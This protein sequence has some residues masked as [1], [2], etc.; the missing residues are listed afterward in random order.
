[1][2]SEPDPGGLEE[3]TPPPSP[4]PT[5]S[6]DRVVTEKNASIRTL[7]G[8]LRAIYDQIED[9]PFPSLAFR[10][11]LAVMFRTSM[12]SVSAWFSAERRRRGKPMASRSTKET[13]VVAVE[14]RVVI[15]AR[16]GNDV[17]MDVT[18]HVPRTWSEAPIVG[19]CM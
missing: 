8:V 9:A 17:P 6:R 5:P 18:L 11:K 2:N 14:T 7:T 15:P 4:T 1:M 10:R 16:G 13:R 19:A 3:T 12:K